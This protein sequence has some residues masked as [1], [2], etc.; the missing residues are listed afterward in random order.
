MDS[1]IQVVVKP[2]WVSWD[3]IKKCLVDAHIINR[4]RG[5]EMSLYQWPVEKI[6]KSIES[7]GGVILVALAESQVVGT[8]AIREKY[9]NAWYT[10]GRYAYMCFGCVLPQYNGRGIYGQLARLREEIA[11]SQSYSVYVLETNER[12]TNMRKIALA[13]GYRIVNYYRPGNH[14]NII[15]A[16]WPAGCP[17]SKLYCRLRFCYSWLHAHLHAWIHAN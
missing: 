7:N 14:Y 11:Q 3:D 8:A 4:E 6:R 9:S 13:N 17:Y 2:D 10:K 1:G 5:V 16:K 15:L 12:N